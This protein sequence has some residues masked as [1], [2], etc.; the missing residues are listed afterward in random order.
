[1]A[2]IQ[3]DRYI[4]HPR[5]LNE[6]KTV[7]ALDQW[8]REH[9]FITEAYSF[10]ALPIHLP[11]WHIRQCPN[12]QVFRRFISFGGEKYRHRSLATN[13]VVLWT[14]T[15][16]T[17]NLNYRIW[18]GGKGFLETHSS[19]SYSTYEKRKAQRGQGDVPRPGSL[20]SES[21]C[22]LVFPTLLCA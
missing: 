10:V 21:E 2:I 1:M 8:I 20:Q 16:R 9:G 6:S 17:E 12:F 15:Q 5:I 22:S 7:S 11:R 3:N 13:L 4:L 18:G 14:I 19:S